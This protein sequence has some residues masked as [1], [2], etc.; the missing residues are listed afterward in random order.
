MNYKKKYNVIVPN[1]PDTISKNPRSARMDRKCPGPSDPKFITD[2]R[3]HEMV[4]EAFR[5]G[6]EEDKNTPPYPRDL[7]IAVMRELNKTRTKEEKYLS[8]IHI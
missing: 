2:K 8:L 7:T 3:V 6:L 4:I 5:K 1:M